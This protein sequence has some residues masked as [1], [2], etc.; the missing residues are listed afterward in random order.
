MAATRDWAVTISSARMLLNSGFGRPYNNLAVPA[1]TVADVMKLTGAEQTATRSAEV[2]A[3][4]DPTGP[5]RGEGPSRESH[6]AT[7]RW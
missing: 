7:D 2:F 6:H 3:R 5:V 1:A 4:S